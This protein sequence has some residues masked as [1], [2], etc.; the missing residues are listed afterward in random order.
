[1]ER[2]PIVSDFVAELENAARKLCNAQ[3]DGL[4][5]WEAYEVAVVARKV[6]KETNKLRG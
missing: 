1:M 3:A 4:A 5:I 2:N 6:M